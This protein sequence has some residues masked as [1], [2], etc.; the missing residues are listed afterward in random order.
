MKSVQNN[1]NDHLM[2]Q[3]QNMNYCKAPITI[4]NQWTPFSIPHSPPYYG[5]RSPLPYMHHRIPSPHPES[6]PPYMQP[7]ASSVGLQSP[8]WHSSTRNVNC[9]RQNVSSDWQRKV[10]VRNRSPHYYSSPIVGYH[11]KSKVSGRG[12]YTPS[13]HP[14][15]S[16]TILNKA[17]QHDQLSRKRLKYDNQASSEDRGKKFRQSL[18][19]SK[20]V[21]TVGSDDETQ[22][23]SLTESPAPKTSSAGAVASLASVMDDKDESHPLSEESQS[24][25]YDSWVKEQLVI[26]KEIASKKTVDSDL[27]T[28]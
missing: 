26:T 21:P 1:P 18:I 4:H 17:N 27:S 8:M 6:R 20:T 23:D 2:C 9:R 22:D 14:Y 7:T 10:P 25:N 28:Q 12:N 19:E 5:P 15:S 24:F 13:N 16:R 3:K 11:E